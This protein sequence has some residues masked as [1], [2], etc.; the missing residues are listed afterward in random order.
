MAYGTIKVDTIT[1]TDAGIDKSVTISGLV[2]N[3][4]FTGNVTV[5]GTVSGATANFVSGVFTTQISG[6]TVTGGNANF[7]SGTFTN[8]SGGVYTITSGVFALGTSGTPSISFASDP[9]TGIY[10]P[11]AYQVAISTN[12]TGKLFIDANGNV[13]VGASSPQHPVHIDGT[14]GAV[15]FRAGVTYAGTGLDIKATENSDVTIDV[16]DST[17]TVARA[18]IFSQAGAERMRLDSSG[19]F[20]FKG[21]G[22]AGVTQAVSFNGSAPVDSLVILSDGKVGLGTSSPGTFAGSCDLAIARTGGSRIGIESTGRFYYIAGD[23]GS[24]RLEIGRRISSNTTDSPGIVLNAT[25]NVGVGTTSPSTGLDLVSSTI[26]NFYIGNTKADATTKFASIAAQQYASATEPEG[27]GLIGGEGSSTANNL[28]IGGWFGEV[29]AAN[30]IAFH[31]AA[32]TTTRSGSERARIDSSG[33]L[34]VGTFS[35]SGGSLLQVNDNRIRIATAKTPASATDTG[36][37]GEICWDANYVYV[38]TA[39]NTW[40]R[41]AIST[42]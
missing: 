29:N 20:R 12:G 40:K 26:P 18:L 31:T 34:L 39:T 23:S 19:G 41:T 15:Q 4:T 25:G 28:H 24:D 9:N 35:Q 38:C 3:P 37:A 14:S 10:S 1:F 32:N 27:F 5:T 8:I 16:N 21:A 33:R 13:G 11:G 36:V 22:T 42:W 2:Q 7:T 30:V 6:A 17:K